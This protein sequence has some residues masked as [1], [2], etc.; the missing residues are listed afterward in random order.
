MLTTE[1][2]PKENVLHKTIRAQELSSKRCGLSILCTVK[3]VTIL[4]TNFSAPTRK[5]SLHC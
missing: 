5:C 1:L 3:H 2:Y 4:Y